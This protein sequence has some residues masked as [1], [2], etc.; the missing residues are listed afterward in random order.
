M[1]GIPKTEM[2]AINYL[3]GSDGQFP[4]EMYTTNHTQTVVANKILI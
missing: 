4:L 3:Y 2:F 1:Q